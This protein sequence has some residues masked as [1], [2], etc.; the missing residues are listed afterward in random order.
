MASPP[1]S[2]RPGPAR[3]VLLV[4]PWFAGS[5]RAWAE[6]VERHSR[7]NISLLTSEPMGWKPRLTR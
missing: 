7:H 1:P 3:D 6:G 5:H 2:P 4:E